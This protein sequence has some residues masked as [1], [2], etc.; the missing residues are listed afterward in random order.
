LPKGIDSTIRVPSRID[1][2]HEQRLHPQNVCQFT[3]IMDP[4]QAGGG[5]SNNSSDFVRKLYK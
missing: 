1:T 3:A 4:S 2:H 5:A